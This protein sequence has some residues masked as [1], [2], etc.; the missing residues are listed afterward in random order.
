MTGQSLKASIPH[1]IL[2]FAPNRVVCGA[3]REHDAGF[4]VRVTGAGVAEV[5]AEAFRV[6]PGLGSATIAEVRVGLRPFSRDSLPLIGPAPGQENLF[7]APVMAHPDFSL[8]RIQAQ[9]SPI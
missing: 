8:V 5:L 3:T 4:D 2:A 1:Y 7:S 6:A 9:P